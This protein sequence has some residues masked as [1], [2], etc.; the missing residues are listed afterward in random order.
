MKKIVGLVLLL[1]VSLFVFSG[2]DIINKYF[3][4]TVVGH[5]EV[6][7]YWVGDKMYTKETLKDAGAEVT[8]DFKEDHTVVRIL[9]GEEKT[10]TYDDKYIYDGDYT[11]D[12]TYE[13]GILT[14]NDEKRKEKAIMQKV[15]K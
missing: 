3:K 15:N 13:N 12:Y 4:D 2:C 6:K 1:F 7:E 11:N 14:V 8:F 5:Y 9:N 10:F